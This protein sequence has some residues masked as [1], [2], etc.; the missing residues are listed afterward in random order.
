M[1][2][3]LV[4]SILSLTLAGCSSNPHAVFVSP[5]AITGPIYGL[6]GGS[7]NTAIAYLGLPDSEIKLA[8]DRRILVWNRDGSRAPVLH[9][10]AADLRGDRVTAATPF[11]TIKAVVGPDNTVSSVEINANSAFYCPRGKQPVSLRGSL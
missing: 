5:G 9:G 6:K 3:I 10:T 4:L 11:C 1:R 8:A 2:R 7:V